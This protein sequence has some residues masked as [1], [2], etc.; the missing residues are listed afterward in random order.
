[1]IGAMSYA[2]FVTLLLGAWTHHSRPW[3]AVMMVVA[4]EAVAVYLL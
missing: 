3:I 2:L 4:A 1:M